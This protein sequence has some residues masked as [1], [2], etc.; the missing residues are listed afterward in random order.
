MG[1]INWPF[2]G[3]LI[4]SLTK[5]MFWAFYVSPDRIDRGPAKLHCDVGFLNWLPV[6]R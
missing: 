5:G 4:L 6:K 2:F 1:P 3:S